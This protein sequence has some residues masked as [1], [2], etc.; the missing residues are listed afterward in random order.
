MCVFFIFSEIDFFFTFSSSIPNLIYSFI[1]VYVVDPTCRL[2][3]EEQVFAFIEYAYNTDNFLKKLLDIESVDYLI[4]LNADQIF[5]QNDMIITEGFFD[6]YSK[7]KNSFARMLALYLL[8][9]ENNRGAKIWIDT[10]LL[11]FGLVYGLRILLLHFVTSVKHRSKA[12]SLKILVHFSW[13]RTFIWW[14]KSVFVAPHD[15]IL[16]FVYNFCVI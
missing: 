6:E 10:W 7:W 1:F 4:P 15:K 9:T 12:F 3:R 8:A 16:L 11:N 2:A 5:A 13:G 14:L